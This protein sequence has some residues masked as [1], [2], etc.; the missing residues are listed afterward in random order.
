ME[1]IKEVIFVIQLLQS[2]KIWVKLPVMVKVA[3]VAA[4]LMAWNIAATS[5]IKHVDNWYKNVNK[6]VEDWIV[7]IL[8]VK[9]TKN[10]SN[11]LTMH[12]GGDLHR[13]H[14]KKMIHEGLNEEQ[15]S[16]IFEDKR[17]GVRDDIHHQILSPE[18]FL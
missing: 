3:N 8:F 2:I 9:S 5:H 11:I 6:Y 13:K 7:K 15:D 4:I 16:E 12:V 1:A 14:S 10:D 18:M 17:M